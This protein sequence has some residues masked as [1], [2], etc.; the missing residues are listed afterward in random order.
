[1]DGYVDCPSCARTVSIKDYGGAASYPPENSSLLEGMDT[2][3]LF[4]EPSGPPL[5]SECG[6]NPSTIRCIDCDANFCDA[7]CAQVHAFKVLASHS[8]GPIESMAA[9]IAVAAAAEQRSSIETKLQQSQEKIQDVF[10]LNLDVYTSEVELLRHREEV[11]E[12]IR[13]EMEKAR[14]ALDRKEQEVIDKVNGHVNDRLAQI[15][16]DL[17]QT[18]SCLAKGH[19]TQHTVC[20][21]RRLGDLPWMASFNARERRLQE[22]LEETDAQLKS[23]RVDPGRIYFTSKNDILSAI[24][25]IDIELKAIN[26][27]SRDPPAQVSFKLILY[28]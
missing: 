22:V 15:R 6:N 2:C 1:M 14:Q 12:E 24:E 7:C 17:F 25:A 21:E 27:R 13:R 9:E 23:V 19:A 20:H 26:G 28:R 4:K 10:Q 18:A 8:R 5:C 16:K 11:V 3:G